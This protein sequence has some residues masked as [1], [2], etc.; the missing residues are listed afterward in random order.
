MSGPHDVFI[1]YHSVDRDRVQPIYAA[2][3]GQ[4]FR[5]FYDR[6]GIEAGDSFPETL[7]RAVKSASVVLG[8]WSVRALEQSK[9]M[10]KECLVGLGRS[11]LLPVALESLPQDGVPVEFYDLHYIDLSGRAPID[12]PSWALVLREI[13]RRATPTWLKRELAAKEESVE[14][15]NQ[16]ASFARRDAEALQI[17]LESVEVSRSSFQTEATH[18][19]ESLR[20][21]NEQLEVKDEIIDGLQLSVE[22]AEQ[23]ARALRAE[24][25]AAKHELL[26]TRSVLNE[27]QLARQASEEHVRSVEERNSDLQQAIA[28]QAERAETA[29]RASIVNLV[30]QVGEQTSLLERQRGKVNE[31]L[32]HNKLLADDLIVRGREIEGLREDRA[33]LGIKCEALARE[34]TEAHQEA[35]VA[36]QRVSELA[37]E[38]ERHQTSAERV[39]VSL[40]EEKKR[41]DRAIVKLAAVRSIMRQQARDVEEHR[42]RVKQAEAEVLE[43]RPRAIEGQAQKERADSAVIRIDEL[44]EEVRA[45][46]RGVAD[47]SQ[48]IDQL[49]S[50]LMHLRAEGDKLHAEF[51]KLTGNVQHYQR[52]LT[53]KSQAIERLEGELTDLRAERD[54]LRAAATEMKTNMDKARA[55]ADGA[56][57]SHAHIAGRLRRR[58]VGAGVIAF[59]ATSVAAVL[60][61]AQN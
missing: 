6:E 51:D 57:A 61:L 21:S 40:K 31:V 33:A 30:K 18:L 52:Q 12:H 9:W 55:Q 5:V 27:A 56:L 46:Q 32:E 17:R 22:K 58:A 3:V 43:L 13:R 26:A 39:S 11:V 2:L 24:V 53:N 49:G 8:C 35:K 47:K 20:R 19:T 7:D 37:S 36:N 60:A 16:E 15:A 14:V 29:A 44:T 10:K 42:T 38:V 48:T 50:Q 28:S 34:M 59:L 23:H 25:E 45:S 4:G 54:G 41:A 1:S